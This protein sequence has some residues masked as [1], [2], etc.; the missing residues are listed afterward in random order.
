MGNVD[1]GAEQE[2]WCHEQQGHQE[3][4][5]HHEQQG[6][7]HQDREQQQGRGKTQQGSTGAVRAS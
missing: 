3:Q 1:R 7:G 4:G 6:L 2:G 5:R